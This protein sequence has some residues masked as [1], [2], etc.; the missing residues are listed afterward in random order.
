MVGLP[1]RGKTFL[2]RKLY[3]HLTWMV[4]VPTC[5]QAVWMREMRAGVVAIVYACVRVRKWLRVCRCLPL[6]LTLP[7]SLCVFCLLSFRILLLASP[8]LLL[9]LPL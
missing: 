3:R 1:A 7:L 9:L 2:A 6:S 5:R 4:C 8:L